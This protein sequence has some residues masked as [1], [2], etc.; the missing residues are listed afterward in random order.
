M[1]SMES[2]LYRRLNKVVREKNQESIETLGPYAAL[3]SRIIKK[4]SKANCEC[5][6]EGEFTVFRGLSLPN[7]I[8]EKWKNSKYVTLD[9]YSS[10]SQNEKI[11]KYFAK[12]SA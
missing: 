8:V 9:G 1:Y 12:D 3:I 11:A 4:K 7:K 5:R 10:S 6:I 2:F